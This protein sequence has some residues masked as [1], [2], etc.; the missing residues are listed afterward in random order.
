MQ[1]PGTSKVWGP[2]GSATP[3]ESSTQLECSSPWASSLTN[4]FVHR[5]ESLF[6][7]HLKVFVRTSECGK[8]PHRGGQGAAL[9]EGT[10]DSG[11]G[12]GAAV[13]RAPGR[14]RKAAYLGRG[15]R[16][17]RPGLRLWLPSGTR[18]RTV[19]CIPR[20]PPTRTRTLIRPPPRAR[21]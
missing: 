12:K 1:T 18:C 4:H 14:P 3:G 15:G 21:A 17:Q 5:K 7:E 2:P 8:V 20:A 10:R 13:R 11:G 16:L 9:P 19:T 6:P